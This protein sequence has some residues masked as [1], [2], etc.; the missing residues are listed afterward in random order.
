[1]RK[2]R[3]PV[4]LPTGN[5]LVRAAV[6]REGVLGDTLLEMLPGTAEYETWVRWM[7]HNQVSPIVSQGE[8][9]YEER[10]LVEAG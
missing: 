1:M 6:E 2:N 8:E 3:L 7:Y 10:V 9:R 5:L 4:L